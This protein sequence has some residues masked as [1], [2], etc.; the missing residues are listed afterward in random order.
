MISFFRIFQSK[1]E[2]WMVKDIYQYTKSRSFYL[3]EKFVLGKLLGCYQRASYHSHDSSRIAYANQVEN[4]PLDWALGAFILLN[5]SKLD[6]QHS[7]WIASSTALKLLF[8]IFLMSIL[9][10]WISKLRKPQV[11]TIYDLE[12]GKYIITRVGR[13]S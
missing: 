12:K 4:V 7:N 8:G 13:Y 6:M 11:K 10:P 9:V 3:K 1:V 2:A 5:S